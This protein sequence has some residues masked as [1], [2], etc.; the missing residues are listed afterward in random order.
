MAK[1]PIEVLRD[2]VDDAN[3]RGVQ[4]VLTNYETVVED[5]YNSVTDVFQA[6]QSVID[7]RDDYDNAHNR[8]EKEEAK[9]N[10]LTLLSDLLEF[11]DG[12][13]SMPDLLSELGMR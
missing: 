7:A 12:L 6:W 2:A 9:E 10:I 3:L 1:T 11:L 13:D 8:E 4:D 5:I